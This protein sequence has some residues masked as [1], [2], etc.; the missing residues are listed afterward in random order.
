MLSIADTSW[1]VIS[2]VIVFLI[3]L[4]I[5]ILQRPTFR[6]PTA[7][8]VCLYIWHTLFCVGY[9]FYSLTNI[10]DATTY[11]MYSIGVMPP[12]EIGTVGIYYLVSIFSKTIGM[13]YFGVFLVFNIF[14]Y[15]GMI[16][17]ASAVGRLVSR[18]SQL[19]QYVGLMIL[20]LPSL[21]WWSSAP[22]KDSLAFLA[23]GLICWAVPRLH[24]RYPAVIVAILV[25]L[26][27]RPYMVPVLMVSLAATLIFDKNTG[28]QTK[29]VFMMA[30]IP[31]AIFA[32]IFSISYVGLGAVGGLVDV[33]DYV[34]TR[35]SYNLEG[36]SS[37]DISSM[38]VP[39]RMFTYVFRP[40][41]F[42]A[43]G[44]MAL[45]VSVENLILL[46]LFLVAIYRVMKQKSTLSIFEYRF[47]M[48]FCIISLL[49]LANTTANLGIAVRQ[50]WMF[51]P[52]LLIIIVSYMER[53]RAQ[54]HY[55]AEVRNR[56]VPS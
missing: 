56:P 20:F 21:S 55:P 33:A 16:A 15:I 24:R 45:G 44:L 31:A 18:K 47:F 28:V 29:T 48:F 37:V 38:N 34:E 13:S 40:L 14:G 39:L 5:A 1:H 6:V 50:K 8:A 52:M 23:V 3:G 30:S 53:W 36:G 4:S 32:L 54:V 17:F 9:F 12:F 27:A 42:D 7:Y 41:F 25:F 2:S 51:L 19:I 26:F 49:M 43:N 35:Q 10:A 11:Y 46:V 22:G